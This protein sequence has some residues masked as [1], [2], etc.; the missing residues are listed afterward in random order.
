[1]K[2]KPFLYW[3]RTLAPPAM[4]ASSCTEDNT[5]VLRTDSVRQSYIHTTEQDVI[6]LEQSQGWTQ[7]CEC[8]NTVTSGDKTDQFLLLQKLACRRGM[9]LICA[10]CVS[11]FYSKDYSCFKAYVQI[12]KTMW[13]CTKPN[14]KGFISN[15]W[16]HPKWMTEIM[17]PIQLDLKYWK[18]S[19]LQYLGSSKFLNLLTIF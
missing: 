7:C 8:T 12:L 16:N 9:N 2:K 3:E 14:W 4:Q 18:L 10:S 15:R 13:Q 17:F 6:V 1:M 5:E 19:S 11:E